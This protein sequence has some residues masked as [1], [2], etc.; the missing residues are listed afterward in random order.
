MNKRVTFRGMDHSPTVEQQV[1]TQLAKIEEFLSHERTPVSLDV[2]LEAHPTHAHNS[3]EM[4]V[5]AP[6]YEAIAQREGKDI[7]KLIGE[8]ADCVYAEL[9]KQKERRVD[10]DKRGV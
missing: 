3:V 10:R 2:V 1:H 9:R 6:D 7:Y 5:H 4:R 8:V